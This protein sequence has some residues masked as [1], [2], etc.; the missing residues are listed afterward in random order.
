MLVLEAASMLKIPVR[1]V[2]PCPPDDFR[3]L[4]VADCDPD[5]PSRYDRLMDSLPPGSL[6]WEQPAGLQN[7]EM[8]RRGNAAILAEAFATAEGEVVVALAVRP[9]RTQEAP[10]ITDD[11]AARAT[12]SGLLL[13]EMDPGVRRTEMKT[14]FVVMPYGKKMDRKGNLIDCESVFSKV[15]V[16]SLESCDIDWA[17]ADQQIDAGIIHIGMLAQ[18]AQADLTVVDTATEN[19]NAFYELGARHVFR[20]RATVLIGPEDADPAF[21]INMLRQVRYKLTGSGVTDANA[22]E[23]IGRLRPFVADATS[24]SV[25]PDSPL[26]QLFQ[27]QPPIVES[28]AQWA[29]P[30]VDLHRRIDLAREKD[31][32]LALARDIDGAG[33]PRTQNAELVLRLAVKL[34]EHRAYFEA[35]EQLRALT[36]PTDQGL[37]YG[38]WCQQLALSERRLGEQLARQGQDPDAYWDKAEE[39]LLTAIQELGDHPET[40]GIAGGLAKRRALRALRLSTADPG[41]ARARVFL[42]RAA[43][44]YGRGFDRQPSNFYTGI[45]LLTVGRI[46]AA[47][48]ATPPERN[49][50]VVATITRFHTER[51]SGDEFWRAATIAE[52][53]LDEH[54]RAAES[55]TTAEVVGA[56]AA[57]LAIPH[58]DDDV[59]PIRDQ[60]ELIVLAGVDADGSARRVLELPELTSA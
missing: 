11:F 2:L 48:G 57:A 5:W 19:A 35:V 43:H 51:G 56:Y 25:T 37:L 33:L 30:A 55:V 40:C 18:L 12:L 34:R 41:D 4:S 38:W 36:I 15:V 1:I 14:A 24:D 3:T 20:P 54:L 32:L 8:L 22:V 10:S 50:D 16:P 13:L 53:M 46:R 7:M 42:D 44:F 6:R 47:Q 39:R 59:G 27:V 52:L 17:R 58:A 28:R 31:A 49:L 26:Y 45:N 23:A 9:K 29:S 21:N 60:L